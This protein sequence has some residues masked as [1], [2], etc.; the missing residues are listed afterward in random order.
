MPKLSASASK[1]EVLQVE[2]PSFPERDRVAPQ[3]WVPLRR[4][5][6]LGD[7]LPLV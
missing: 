3:R 5:R 6:L 2:A 7:P 1:E 4:H